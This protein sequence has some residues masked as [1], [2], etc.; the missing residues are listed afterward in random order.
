[1]AALQTVTNL[2]SLCPLAM[3]T[4]DNLKIASQQ[5]QVVLLIWIKGLKG[6]ERADLLVKEAAQKLKIKPDYDLYPVSFA[7]RRLR[8][9]TLGE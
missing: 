3:E 6:N 2:A 5:K 1:M 9:A 4:R 7:K 8:M